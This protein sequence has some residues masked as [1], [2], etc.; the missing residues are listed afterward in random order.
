MPFRNSQIVLYR[1]QIVLYRLQNILK[2]R[3]SAEGIGTALRAGY[4]RKRGSILFRK[5]RFFLSLICVASTPMLEN[6]SLLLK[7]S[8]GRF[9]CRQNRPE[10]QVNPS[11]TYSGEANPTSKNL[12]NMQ[13]N[14]FTYTSI[15][16][17]ILSLFLHIFFF[18]SS[19]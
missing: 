7:G 8:S 14:V 15:F 4:V 16:I 9:T 13:R 10:H 11:P 18:V 1:L 19:P 17:L 2:R 3:G 5:Q 12:H 6:T